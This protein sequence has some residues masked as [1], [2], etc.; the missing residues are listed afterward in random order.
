MLDNIMFNE[1]WK[2]VEDYEIA[3]RTIRKGGH[4]LRANA[5][6]ARKPKNGTNE[7]GLH[8]RYVN[9]ELGKW[10]ARLA[11]VYPEFK[12]NKDKTGGHIKFG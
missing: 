5:L 11:L 1:K 2:M 3:L 4:T 10:I 8:E 9:G 6:C 7:G 12:P